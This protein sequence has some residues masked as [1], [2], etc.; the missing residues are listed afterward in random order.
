[1]SVCVCVCV[2]FEA[3]PKEEI[4]AFGDFLVLISGGKKNLFLVFLY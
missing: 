4:G 3:S 1:V 2:F